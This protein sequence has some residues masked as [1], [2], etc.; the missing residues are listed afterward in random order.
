LAACQLRA[1]RRLRRDAGAQPGR[2][3]QPAH[4]QGR[5]TRLAVLAHPQRL[6]AACVAAPGAAPVPA[7]RLLEAVRDEE[8]RPGRVGAPGG[9]RAV[10]RDAGPRGRRRAARGVGAAAAR[11][12]RPVRR[13]GC[14][15]ERRC[16]ARAWSRRR[17]RAAGAGRDCRVSP[18]L[19]RR[20]ADR[21]VGRPAPRA[22]TRA[23]RVAV[24]VG[25]MDPRRDDE[26]QAVRA[27]YARRLLQDPRYSPLNPAALLALQERQR[28][29][30]RLFA[31]LGFDD[32]ST[33]RLLEVGSG[34]GSN[35]L[36]LLWM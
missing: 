4:L 32:L 36:E 34:G 10:R 7:I 31:R 15:D 29:L 12:G 2:R 24:E 1:L 16:R 35:L 27:R 28:A 5:R 26:V 8:T 17:R 19:W 25:R 3:A 11:A 33:L 22:R 21:R 13:G 14:G 20:L 30:A 18:G 23:V 9:A 6:P